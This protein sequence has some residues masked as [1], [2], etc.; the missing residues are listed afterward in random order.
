M[1]KSI[2]SLRVENQ[3]KIRLIKFCK[4]IPYKKYVEEDE[5]IKKLNIPAVTIKRWCAS[6]KEIMKYISY[7]NDASG[8]KVYSSEKTKQLLVTL[9][10]VR[11]TSRHHERY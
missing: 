3:R 1:Y 10:L 9:N 11:K 2:D 5:I 4:G 6:N 7:R 8:K